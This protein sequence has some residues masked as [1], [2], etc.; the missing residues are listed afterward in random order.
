MKLNQLEIK[1]FTNVVNYKLCYVKLTEAWGSDK[2]RFDF[3]LE[4]TKRNIWNLSLYVPDDGK[5]EKPDYP[6]LLSA[7]SR[8]GDRELKW[9]LA[10][11][12]SVSDEAGS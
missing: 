9:T 4:R 3:P 2:N 12:M 11:P 8:A 6:S 1:T 10:S 7:V 5:Q